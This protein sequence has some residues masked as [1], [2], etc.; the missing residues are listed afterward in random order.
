MIIWGGQWSIFSWFEM[1][2]HTPPTSTLLY[3]E[4]RPNTTGKAGPS[5]SNKGQPALMSRNFNQVWLKEPEEPK[6]MTW[7]SNSPDPKAIQDSGM[8]IYPLPDKSEIKRTQ[9]QL[10]TMSN[11]QGTKFVICYCSSNNRGKF[12]P[13]YQLL[14]P[15]GPWKPQRGTK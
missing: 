8:L 9:W 6:A 15:F 10:R 12:A 3:N 13:G 7:P 1:V 14:E 11:Y 4:Y 2:Q 5:S